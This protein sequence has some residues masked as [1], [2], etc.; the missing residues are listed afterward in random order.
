M[1]T[2]ARRAIVA[3][4]ALAAVA[5]GIL[6]LRG[7]GAERPQMAPRAVPRVPVRPEVEAPRPPFGARLLRPV[8]LRERPGGRGVRV[9]GMRTGYG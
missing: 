6:L 8:L 9:L 7:V 3:A 5:V 4:I 1:S 2:V